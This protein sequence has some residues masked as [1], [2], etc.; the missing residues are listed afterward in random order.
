L[1]QYTQPKRSSE[2][3]R[4]GTTPGKTAK[5]DKKTTAKTPN[6]CVAITLRKRSAMVKI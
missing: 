6:V 3:C 2:K 5:S 4:Y 1:R